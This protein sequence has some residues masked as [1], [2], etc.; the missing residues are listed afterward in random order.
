MQCSA[1]L[2][3]AI[4]KLERLSMLFLVIGKRALR[5]LI[6]EKIIE[7]LDID[8][9]LGDLLIRMGKLPDINGKNRIATKTRKF[10]LINKI[11]IPGNKYYPFPYYWA[12]FNSGWYDV[13]QM[14]PGGKKAN[15]KTAL[16]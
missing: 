7:V 8:N 5:M 14:I 10:A 1:A 13:K 4:Q 3:N 11:P 9:P 15:S 16:L 12:I 6:N 2:K